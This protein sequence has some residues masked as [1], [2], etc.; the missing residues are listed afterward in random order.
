MVG[1]GAYGS[2]ISSIPTMYPSSAQ[3]MVYS[4]PGK[5]EII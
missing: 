4:V 3:S 5:K 2:G 1:L